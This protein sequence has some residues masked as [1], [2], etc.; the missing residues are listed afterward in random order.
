MTTLSRIAAELAEYARSKSP[1]KQA[2]LE[3][4]TN[5]QI[6][7]SGFRDGKIIWKDVKSA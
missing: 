7:P 3:P 1:V 6:K 2:L 4:Y 5:G